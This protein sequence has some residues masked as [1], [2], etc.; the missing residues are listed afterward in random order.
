MHVVFLGFARDLIASV[1]VSVM[2]EENLRHRDMPDYLR[3]LTISMNNWLAAEK[4]SPVRRALSLSNINFDRSKSGYPELGSCFKAAHVKSMIHFFAHWCLH[5]RNAA[6]MLRSVCLWSLA[7]FVHDCD[8]HD[9]HINLHD[10]LQMIAH[11]RLHLLSYQ[12]LASMAASAQV[13]LFKIRPKHHSFDEILQNLYTCS[14]NPMRI[15]CF[16]D[17]D[18][19][20]KIKKIATHCHGTTVL[21]QTVRRYL[22]QLGLRFEQRR[23]SGV[24][25]L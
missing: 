24:F 10:R 25:S 17:E 2:L 8:A 1:I 7:S 16:T 21:L 18:F 19:L 13:R 9:L 5:A 15:S 12:C 23:R 4:R 6:G 11:G 14:L 22:L 3:D 20:G